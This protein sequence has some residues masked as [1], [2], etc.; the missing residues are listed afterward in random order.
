MNLLLIAMT[1]QNDY[2]L[3]KSQLFNAMP[4]LTSPSP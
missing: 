2:Q 4:S 3:V 1:D